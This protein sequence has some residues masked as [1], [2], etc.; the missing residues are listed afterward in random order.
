MIT[1]TEPI[2]PITYDL[3]RHGKPEDILFFDIETTGL[4]PDYCTIYLIGCVFY[5][6]GQWYLK[7]FFAESPAAEG[8]IL[9]HFF[10]M[11]SKY[12]VLIHFNGDTFDIPFINK[13]AA[14]LNIPHA[15]NE[16]ESLDIYRKL[17]PYKKLLGIPD[18]RQKTI[19]KLLGIHREDIFNGGQLIEVYKDYLVTH[20]ERGKQFL[21]LHNADD[22][23][24]MPALLPA[25]YYA[26]LFEGDYT[27]K[28]ISVEDYSK[29]NIPDEESATGTISNL[30]YGKNA[31][32]LTFTIEFEDIDLPALLS[33]ADND[34]YTI[35]AKDNIMNV[36]I[37]VINGEL[38]HFFSDYKN[39]F[40]L[41]DEDI[42]IHKSVAEFVDK[43][44]KK[45]ATAKNCYTKKSGCFIPAFGMINQPMFYHE[46]P[47]KHGYVLF[48]E[49]MLSDMD[50]LFDYCD[51]MIKS[52]K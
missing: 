48:D 8:E 36:T 24:G 28:N 27:I 46:Y 6:D 22:L 34:D 5:S 45:R 9:F 30:E 44:H 19:E 14:R 35:T 42:A 33:I 20:D 7:Q 50:F 11:L 25:L 12:S 10:T 40:Y 3:S 4:S 39:Y 51:S 29:N 38:K 47:L 21:L 32:Q 41:P 43:E 18:C 13:R 23:R 52:I 17:K 1:I 16:F 37:N 31:G 2:N 49:N 26:R 15:A